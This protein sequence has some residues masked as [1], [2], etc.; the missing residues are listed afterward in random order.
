[1]GDV[2]Y[3]VRYFPTAV[4][5]AREKLRKLEQE[6][7]DMNAVDLLTCLEAAGQAWDREAET[8][9]LRNFIKDVGE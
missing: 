1:M 2:Y 3:R 9:R 7:R 8:A 5:R 6:A 4:E